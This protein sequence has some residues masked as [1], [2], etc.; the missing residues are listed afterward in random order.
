MGAASPASQVPVP[1]AADHLVQ[2]LVLE[3]V[4]QVFGVRQGAVLPLAQALARHAGQGRA[5]QAIEHLAAVH[6]QSAVHA[7]DGFARCSGEVGVCLVPSGPGVTNAVTGIATA[8]MDSI[9]LVVIT[10]QVPTHA[11]GQDSFQEVDTIGIT[12]SCVKH[13]L[14]LTDPTAVEDTVR[15]AFHL[16]RSGRPGPVLIDLPHDVATTPLARAFRPGQL[17]LRRQRSHEVPHARQVAHAAQALA[18]ATR[19]LIYFGGGVLASGATAALR[20]LAAL[21]G[22]PVT[23]TLMGLGAFDATHP[24]W[25]GMLG[26]HGLVE[27]NMATQHCD[28]LIAIGARFDDRVI[29][30]PADFARAQRRIVHIDIDPSSIAKRVKADLPIVADC[31]LALEALN[32]LLRERPVAQRLTP[33]RLAPWMAQIDRWRAQRCLDYPASSTRIKP[34]RVLQRLA[35]WAGTRDIVMTSDVGQHQMWAAQYFPFR[36]PRQWINSGGLGTMGFG[37]P[38]AMGAAVA[39]RRH[40]PGAA[41]VCITG[42][43]SLQMSTKEL[44]ACLQWGVPI[45][46]ICL[47]NRQLGMVRQ[48]QDFFHGSRRSQSYMHAMPDFV[49]L[50][51]AYGH[52]GLR[53][54]DPQALDAALA[55]LLDDTPGLALLEVVT[56]R[57]EN[58]YPTLGANQPLTGMLLRAPISAEDL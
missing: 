25:L 2:A 15:E 46:I 8:Y 7:A 27:A 34:Q 50:A 29:G 26:M 23:G 1:T 58:V 17:R 54:E 11:L 47:N 40:R 51:Q 56:D 48:Q 42:D 20:E 10:G 30:D 41:V 21:S 18:E 31:R 4:R 13:S 3:G 22:A 33:D 55:Q 9:P 49:Q 57:E 12:R 39:A 38:A 19:P 45:K 35:H 28:L 14:M 52:T 36:Q 53:V 6:E 37:L 43:G 5:D 44:S 24:Q 16:A 32:A